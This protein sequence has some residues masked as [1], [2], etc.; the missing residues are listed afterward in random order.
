MPSEQVRIFLLLLCFD[1]TKKLV[2][3][4]LLLKGVH[5]SPQIDL[6]MCVL[7]V[8]T[9]F[10]SHALAVTLKGSRKRV[11][12]AGPARMLEEAWCSGGQFPHLERGWQLD[13]TTLMPSDHNHS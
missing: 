6:K 1:I 5:I 3:F 13:R 10:Q 4:V 7:H 11:F 8:F 9:Y 12:H 2:K